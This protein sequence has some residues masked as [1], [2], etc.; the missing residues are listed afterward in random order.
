MQ[1]LAPALNRATIQPTGFSTFRLLVFA[2]AIDHDRS[3]ARRNAAARPGSADGGSRSQIPLPRAPAMDSS[4][5]SF[6]GAREGL[7][8][9]HRAFRRA[10]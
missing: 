8:G 4:T 1:S 10:P 2:I 9:R 3:A 7:A 6:E 5:G